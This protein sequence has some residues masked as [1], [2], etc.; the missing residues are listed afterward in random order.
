M[1][2]CFCCYVIKLAGETAKKVLS[3]IIWNPLLIEINLSQIRSLHIKHK[4]VFAVWPYLYFLMIYI[5]TLDIRSEESIALD[6]KLDL[7][8]LWFSILY[9]SNVLKKCFRKNFCVCVC[10]SVCLPHSNS[11]SRFP[12][13]ISPFLIFLF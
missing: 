10:V 6:K 8:F 5:F 3:S 13:Q 9:H 2:N 4:K 1:I 11:I 12:L 7:D